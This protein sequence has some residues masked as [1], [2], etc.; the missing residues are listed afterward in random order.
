M[1]KCGLKFLFSTTSQEF[2]SGMKDKGVRGRW[3]LKQRKT[4]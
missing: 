1:E 4:R 3:R 2:Y